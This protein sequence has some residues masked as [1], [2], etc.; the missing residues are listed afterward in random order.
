MRSCLLRWIL[1]VCIF[2]DIASAN[3]YR[4][5]IAADR[6]LALR[7]AVTMTWR[8]E[9]ELAASEIPLR[10]T[11]KLGRATIGSNSVR[12]A[13]DRLVLP[14]RLPTGS[15]V[16]VRIEFHS[17][18]RQGYGYPLFAGSWHPKALTWRKGTF[19]AEQQQ[20]D[21]YDVT[22][23]APKEVVVASAG[24][25]VESA[26]TG[27]GQ[28]RYHWR[29]ARATGFGLAAS[30]DFVETKRTQ[31]GVEVRLFELRGEPRF[32][33]GMAEF[34]VDAIGFYKRLFGFYP[35]PALVMLPGWF[36][37][38]GGYSPI[39]G[40]TVYHRN[41][42][43]YRQAIVAHEIAHQYWGYDTVID[44]GDYAHWPGLGLGIYTDGLY[45]AATRSL[46]MTPGWKTFEQATAK[47][48][49]T[50]ILRP[51]AQLK[52]MK[53]DWNSGVYHYKAYA[54]MRMLADLMGPDRFLTMMHGLLSN[55]RH[56]WLPA[57]EFQSAVETAA[58]RKL[59]WFFEDWVRGS[60]VAR[61]SIETV[62]ASEGSVD[63][64]IRRSG[65]ARFPVEVKLISADG[66]E[67][68]QRIGEN[69]DLQTLHFRSVAAKRVE[70]D[71]RGQCPMIKSGAE[72]WTSRGRGK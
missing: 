39:S 72:V 65:A 19:R 34:A 12:V 62:R 10:C 14:T 57:E 55:Y 6:R 64:V 38:G 43:E 26:E 33:A 36:K 54:V 21:D 61:F 47:G 32:D 51:R 56:S 49:D 18:P 15:L 52:R 24:E 46:H 31:D 2:E 5:E 58:G 20:A 30:T 42:G 22:L 41:T 8:N 70:I 68:V 37:S 69:A 63:I 16:T 3:E 28:R 4:I 66:S 7:G 27:D 50:T 29:L 60:G 53:F 48:L 25:T 35:H 17:K 40:F 9:T 71:P 11:C 67:Q 59:D 45:A 1:P 13:G 23:T 44:D